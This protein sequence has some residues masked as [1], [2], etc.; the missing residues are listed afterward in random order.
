MLKP[1]AHCISISSAL[2]LAYVQ[3]CS[4][5]VHYSAQPAFVPSEF[6]ISLPCDEGLWRAPTS[7]EW[8]QLLRRPSTYGDG[9]SRMLGLNMQRVLLSL[10]QPTPA[11]IPYVINP[12]STFVLI[13]NI[14]RDIFSSRS[15]ST[16]IVASG[17]PLSIQ[18]AL[19]NWQRM[20]TEN[21]EALHLDQ[22]QKHAIPFVHNALPLYWLARFAEGA[23]DNNNNM[24]PF[25]TA[26]RTEA[27]GL[28]SNVE[29]RYRIVKNWLN[30]IN[31]A[32]HN[33][34]QVLPSLSCRTIPAGTAHF[35]HELYPQ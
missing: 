20:W 13:H 11:V 19:H 23:K 33:G 25:N 6:E 34:S 15:R 2:L 12:F 8:F 10:S 22:Q 17:N 3:D 4:Y 7:R 29:D 18:C 1:A 14:L 32:L 30:Q 27:G 26:S 21:P 28:P 5:C 35:S 31:S 16:T 24:V 9:P